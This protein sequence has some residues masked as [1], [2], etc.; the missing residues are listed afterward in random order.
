MDDEQAVLQAN[1]AFYDAFGSA[2]FAAMVEVWAHDDDVACTHP[3]WNVLT[4]YHDVIESWR[5]ILEG[6]AAPQILWRDARAFVHGDTAFVTC[7]EVVNGALLVATNIFI[8]KIKTW[9][10]VHHHAGPCAMTESPVEPA[11]I[12]SIH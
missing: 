7:N 10:I 5:A 12:D 9:T 3:G 4:G 2:D 11:P 1:E 6:A 8:R